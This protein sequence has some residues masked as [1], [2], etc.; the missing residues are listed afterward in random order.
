MRRPQ[1]AGRRRRGR[2]GRGG[3]GKPRTAEGRGPQLREEG[4]SARTGDWGVGRD[5]RQALHQSNRFWGLS[6]PGGAES[7]LGLREAPAEEG[8]GVR[9]SPC[10]SLPVTPSW[11]GPAPPNGQRGGEARR[12]KVPIDCTY[13][14][15]RGGGHG[16]ADTS[17]RLTELYQRSAP[18]PDL[19]CDSSSA[20]APPETAREQPISARLLTSMRLALARAVAL[21]TLKAQGPQFLS[22]PFSKDPGPTSPSNLTL[23]APFHLTSSSFLYSP[24]LTH[25]SSPFPTLA[26]RF[27][28]V[29]LSLL[30]CLPLWMPQVPC[31]LPSALHALSARL[32]GAPFSPRLLSSPHSRYDRPHPFLPHP[33]PF[34]PPTPHPLSTLSPPQPA[35]GVSDDRW[36]TPPRGPAGGG[37]GAGRGDSCLFQAPRRRRPPQICGSCTA[38]P[39][40]GGCPGCARPPDGASCAPPGPRG[41]P[42]SGRPSG[43]GN[44][45]P[46]RCLL[47]RS[48]YSPLRGVLSSVEATPSPWAQ[49]TGKDF[50]RV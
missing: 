2:V 24:L 9:P 18:S 7:G 37:R 4:G 10:R 26:R 49:D 25:V 40:A 45:S 33:R 31:S 11:I 20:A 34:L 46:A 17:L 27:P 32:S 48:G 50:V 6:G 35:M 30:T 14:E 29:H 41:P 39:S 19:L 44:L 36:A 28:P 47:G 13:L 3:P 43:P 21:T 42:S 38:G 8:Q 1:R 12:T 5:G 22:G 23:S 16:T 15:M